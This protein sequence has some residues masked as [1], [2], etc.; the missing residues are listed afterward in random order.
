M[1][2]IRQLLIASVCVAAFGTTCVAAEITPQAFFRSAKDLSRDYDPDK[3]YPRGQIFP[4]GFFGLNMSRDKIEGLTLVGPYGRERNVA[5]AKQHGLECTYNISLPMDFHGE[6]PLELT[7]D[8]IRR[9]IGQQVQ[10]AAGNLEIA[11]W[12]LGP[13]ELRFWRQNELTYLEVAAETIRRTDPLKRPVWMYDPGHRDAE[14]LAH[15][16]KHL[17]ICGKGMYTNYSGQGDNRVWVR[18][19]IE[20]EIGAIQEANPSAIPIAVPE[21]FQDPPEELLPMIPRWV[22]HDV[23][24]SLICGAKGIMVFSGFRRSKFDTFD[25]YHQAYATC[26]RQINGPLNLGQVFLFGERRQDVRVRVTSG[27]ARIATA[28]K[29][30]VE[31]PSVAML[32]VSHGKDRYL[33]LANSA[34]QPVGVVIE[35]LPS[36]PIGVENLFEPDEEPNLQH[37]RFELK[38]ESLAV[39]AYRFTAADER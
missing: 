15:T 7:P 9:Q 1:Q 8:Q 33:F 34:N 13:E 37:G 18:W 10:E 19:T 21:M 26:A 24:L 29:E 16:V 5:D 25:R 39:K 23:Y 11:W 32:D 2:T 28:H 36:V 12:Y 38:L 6:K 35:G 22:R 27:P 17:D 20:Q 3:V 14:A 31:Y 30:P 4:L